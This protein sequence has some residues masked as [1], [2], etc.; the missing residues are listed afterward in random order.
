M[1]K[2]DDQCW[3]DTVDDEILE[4]SGPT[5]GMHLDEIMPH[6]DGLAAEREVV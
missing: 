1:G 2:F 3:Q 6:L 5:D 4:I